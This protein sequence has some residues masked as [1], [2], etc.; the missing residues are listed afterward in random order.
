[1]TPMAIRD[2]KC[3]TTIWAKKW[4]VAMNDKTTGF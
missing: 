1:M 4:I 3:M 2:A